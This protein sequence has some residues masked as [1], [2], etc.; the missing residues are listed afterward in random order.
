MLWDFAGVDGLAVAVALFGGPVKKLAPWRSLVTPDSRYAVLR[1]CEGNFRIRTAEGDQDFPAKLAQACAEKRV[2][3]AQL[4]YLEALSF[5]RDAILPRLEQVATPK[6]PFRLHHL[7]IDC[8]LPARIDSTAIILW[9]YCWQ[10][11]DLVQ[12][13][14]SREHRQ[15]ISGYLQLQ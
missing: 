8:A 7:P 15:K 9:R 1:L 14:C 6:P 2:W 3:Y 5:P 12:I 13:H 10:G 4:A 11:A